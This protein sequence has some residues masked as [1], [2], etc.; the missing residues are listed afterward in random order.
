MYRFTTL[1]PSEF[2][3]YLPLLERLIEDP[4]K[5]NQQRPI[6]QETLATAT[7]PGVGLN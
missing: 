6:M 4:Q 7:Q 5:I 3:G 2:L 1:F